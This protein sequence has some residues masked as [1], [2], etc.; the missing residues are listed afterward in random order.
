MSNDLISIIIPNYNKEKFLEI[1]LQSVINQNY[2][3]WEAIIVDDGSTDNSKQIIEKYV[4]IDNRFK[5]YFLPKSKNGGSVSRNFGLKNS[6]GEW[7]IF[8]DSDDVLSEKC[9]KNRID[10]LYANPNL[11]FAV[12]SMATFISEI[13][14]IVSFWM[15]NID[16]AID[17]FLSHELPW[18]TMQPI[19]RKS[20]LE[21]NNLL[22]NEHIGRLQ[23]VYF[24]TEILLKN[25]LFA[26]CSREPD[27]FFRIDSDRKTTNEY[28][29]YDNWI[30]SVIIYFEDFKIKTKNL[31]IKELNKTIIYALSEINTARIQKRI[32]RIQQSAL[33]NKLMHE[34][35]LPILIKLYQ[36]IIIKIPFHMKGLRKLFLFFI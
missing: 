36:F 3:N 28:E 27:C 29:F 4:N 1:T 32:N 18:Q 21:R 25:P 13:S 20:F 30:N 9:L 14:N 19:Y 2:K 12:S 26:V 11:D 10:F 34:V 8:L 23:D 31:K 7:I 24:H 17:R 6:K 16:N 22:F 15:P 33:F 5:S 35:D